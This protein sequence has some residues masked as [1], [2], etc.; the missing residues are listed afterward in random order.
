M[1]Q[2]QSENVVVRD[3]NVVA[4]K[5]AIKL[6]LAVKHAIETNETD[7][8]AIW[9]GLGIPSELIL[10]PGVIFMTNQLMHAST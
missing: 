6:V 4:M 2:A 7:N 8:Q 1:A 5:I 3:A 9:V 10:V